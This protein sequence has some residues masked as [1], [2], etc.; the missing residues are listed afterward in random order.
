MQELNEAAVKAIADA[1]GVKIPEEELAQL[2][3]RLNGMIA[4]LQPLEDLPL[5]DMELIP[6]LLTQG[7]G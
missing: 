5:D 3:I 1:V 2:T 6:T 7:G 4:L